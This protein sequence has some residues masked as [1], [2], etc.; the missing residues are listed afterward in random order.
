MF[1]IQNENG[2]FCIKVSGKLT[3][4]DYQ[5]HLIPELEKA[6][7]ASPGAHEARVLLEAEDFHG[8]EW[9][10]ALDDLKMGIKHRKDFRKIAIVGKKEWEKYL[11]DIFGLMM[12]GEIQFYDETDLAAAKTWLAA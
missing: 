4:Q 6:I 5:E 12:T 2:L 3:H 11:K 9:R 7:A 10:A 8:W 1:E